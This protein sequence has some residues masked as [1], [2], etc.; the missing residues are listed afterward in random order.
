MTRFVQESNYHQPYCF[1]GAR[2]RSHPRNEMDEVTPGCLEH[3][4]QISPPGL[5]YALKG[6][7]APS[8][9]CSHQGFL[10]SCGG[11]D[12]GGYSCCSRVSRCFP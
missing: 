3:S 5:T 9:D 11:E 10:T 8:C 7:S 2:N 4:R 12:V 6:N 1:E